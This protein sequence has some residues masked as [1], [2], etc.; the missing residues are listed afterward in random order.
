[1][2]HKA[3]RS[4]SELGDSHFSRIEAGDLIL[5]GQFAWEGAVALAKER[6]SG[7]VASHRYPILRGVP[8]YVTSEMLLALLRTPYGS[9]LLD[10]H[11]RGAAGRNRPLNLRTLLK[12]KVPI[13]QL[14]QQ[15]QIG[16][17]LEQEYSVAQALIRALRLVR[18][19]RVR[20]TTDMVTGQLDIRVAAQT[21]PAVL[22]KIESD[23]SVDAA[24]DFEFESVADEMD[25]E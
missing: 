22:D 1:M 23:S 6:D 10:H 20:L 8:Q 12:E 21:L 15:A 11:S 19:H 4:G 17:L 9:V 7:C 2:F 18:E 24:Q 25:D 5:S 14:K 16:E 3:T 13:P